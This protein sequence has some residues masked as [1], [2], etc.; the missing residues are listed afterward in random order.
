M[1]I[2]LDQAKKAITRTI[3]RAKVSDTMGSKQMHGIL[4]TILNTVA[5]QHGPAVANS[6]IILHKLQ[7]PS[8]GGFKYFEEP[9][10]NLED[11]L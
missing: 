11:Y 5:K 10:V 8:R 2:T 6:L 9:N 1:D 4:S 3:G 7:H